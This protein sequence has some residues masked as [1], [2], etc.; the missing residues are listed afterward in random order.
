MTLITAVEYDEC[1]TWIKKKRNKGMSW[2]ALLLAGK[3]SEK[4]LGEFLKNK[5][6]EDDWP[7]SVNVEFWKQLIQ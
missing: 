4:E 6:D 5:V 1:R 2:D 3:R 7:S